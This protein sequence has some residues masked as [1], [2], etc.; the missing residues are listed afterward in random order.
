MT[1]L[2]LGV[3]C[4]L[5]VTK[6]AVISSDGHEL[7]VASIP[8]LHESPRPRW[9]ERDMT[10][11]QHRVAEVI[12]QA[13][14]DARVDGRD[15]AGVG[16]TGHGDGLYLV[17]E[18][19]APVRPGVLSMDSRA[20]DMLAE[21]SATGDLERALEVTGQVPFPGSTAAITAWMAEFEPESLFRARWILS[22]KDW[23]KLGLTGEV[24]TDPTD[25]SST[26]VDVQLQRYSQE[27]LRV[28]RLEHVAEKL[29][30]ILPSDAIA[31][32]ITAGAAA[33]TGLAAGTPVVAGVHDV[34]ASAIG[35]GCIQPGQLS[36]VAGSFSINQTIADRPIVDPRWLCRSFMEPGRWMHLGVSPAS[37]SNLE[38]LA[39]DV[40]SIPGTRGLARAELFR[41]LETEVGAVL[42]RAREVW[43]LPFLYGS[44]LDNRASAAFVGLRGW[45][46]RADVTR[47]LFEGVVFN[48]LWHVLALSTVFDLSEVRLAG[49]GS[50]SQTWAQMFADAMDLPVIVTQAEETGALGSAICAGIGVG[51]YSSLEDAVAS[52]VH[53]R[54]VY[55]PR[56]DRHSDLAEGFA[57]YMEIADALRPIWRGSVG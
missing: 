20:V 14:A 19:G 48:H 5:T 2:L 53:V 42:G 8:L 24:S 1:D 44:P 6:A 15:I 7:A 41:L 31:G 34:D 28:Y 18:R 55:E 49:G 37:A 13:L 39:A 25:G 16:V 10:G 46:T 11:L 52:V 33:A 22:C 4:G 36:V 51:R 43:Y 56:A 32:H 47:A 54:H 27:A 12:R 30:P 29:P 23:I 9:I 35:T 17:D 3:D 50:R 26:F 57:K 38:W 40:L 45:H 21:R